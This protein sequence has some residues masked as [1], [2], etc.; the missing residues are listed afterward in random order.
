MNKA[1]FLQVFADTLGSMSETEK[2]DILYDYA[3]HFSIGL[4]KGKTEEEVAKS[5]G[6]PKLL[7]RQYKAEYAVKRAETS[8]SAGDVFR[9]VFAALGLGFLNLVFV[10]GP[11]LGV[12]GVMIGFFAAAIGITVAGLAVILGVILS[13]LFPDI[14]N[15][16]L[17]F[18]M[19]LFAGTGLSALGLLMLLGLAK[20]TSLLLKG[21]IAYLKMNIGIIT[22][23]RSSN[24]E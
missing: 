9:A 20:L 1:E 8:S 5:L 7:A 12:A 10:L 23:R 13:P 2:Q 11:I 16:E 24:V 21:M 22:G 3:E 15:I 6:D 4:E 19:Y 17:N 18:A 14:I